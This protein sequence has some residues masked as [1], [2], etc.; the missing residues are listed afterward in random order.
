LFALQ[1]FRTTGR[2][3]A[4]QPLGFALYPS[5]FVVWVSSLNRFPFKIMKG[6]LMAKGGS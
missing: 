2:L 6:L 3:H 4:K 1:I 5:P